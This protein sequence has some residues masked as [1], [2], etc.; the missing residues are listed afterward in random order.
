MP[1]FDIVNELD[2]A[3]IDNAINQ[4]V[5]EI[6]TRFDFRGGKSSIK[7]DKDNKLINIL[8][9][10]EMKLRSI[11]QIIEA[12]MSKRGIDIRCLEFGKEEQA[13]GNL[14]K[15]VVSLKEGIEK[16]NAKK[17]TKLIKDMKLKVQAQVQD[18]QV[19]VSGKKIDDLQ[20][21]ISQI[22]TGRRRIREHARA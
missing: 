6:S 7:L 4:A 14:I 9:D 20:E 15:Q 8:A 22:E 21:V 16:D 11:H 17:I 10:D 18:Q 1:S 3:E 13:S 2:F 5:K 19:R 12:K